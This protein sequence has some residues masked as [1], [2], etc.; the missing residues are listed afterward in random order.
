MKEWRRYSFKVNG[1]EIETIYNKETI[2]NVFLPLLQKLTKLQKEKQERIIVFLAAPPAVGK[3]TWSQFLEYLSG[4]ENGLTEIQAIGLDGF[5]FHSDYIN[6]HDAVVF[7]KKVPMKTVKGCP[8]TYDTKKLKNKLEKI[9]TQNIL[10]PSYDR[11]IHDVVEDTESVT[12]D[13]ILIEGNWLLLDEEPWVS[14]KNIADYTILIRANEEML[15][16][17]LIERKMQGGL[18]REK[19]QAW[20]HKSDSVNIKRVLE[21]SVKADLTLRMEKDGDYMRLS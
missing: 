13:I 3:T 14:M 19:A 15:K 18:S 8:E 5:H 6:S 16:E 7:G 9:K 20:Y 4:K 11:N 2:K 21:C 1:F 10:W 17:R 12:K